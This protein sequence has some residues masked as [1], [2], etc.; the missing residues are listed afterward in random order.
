M[1]T[2]YLKKADGTQVPVSSGGG[3]GGKVGFEVLA[4][5]PLTLVASTNTIIPWQTPITAIGWSLSANGNEMV[6]SRA[7]WYM[8]TL[9]WRMSGSLQ[10]TPYTW[11]SALN[12]CLVD[13][14]GIGT[15]IARQVASSGGSQVAALGESIST[16][17]Y[18]SDNPTA[19]DVAVRVV[20]TQFSDEDLAIGPIRMQAF[21]V[22]AE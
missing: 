8:V 19:A 18:F 7:G 12:Q 16:L 6:C 10:A 3:G 4:Q 5:D 14:S 22:W 2:L 1:G 11:N 20:M 21:L 17:Q 13:E 15:N 9:N